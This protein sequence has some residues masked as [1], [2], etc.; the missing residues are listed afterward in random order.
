LK[1]EL[2]DWK[3]C[4][5]TELDC[6]IDAYVDVIK[7]SFMSNPAYKKF[8]KNDD[9][10]TTYQCWV[11]DYNA[12]QSDNMRKKI[13]VYPYQSINQGDYIYFSLSDKPWL[14]TNIDNI[15][16]WQVEGTI[17]KCSNY[18]LKWKD[19]KLAIYE[20]YCVIGYNRAWSGYQSDPYISVLD[21]QLILQTQYNVNTSLI[22]YNMRIKIGSKYYMMTKVLEQIGNDE[23]NLML[24]TLE[25]IE[26]LDQDLVYVS[27]DLA[28]NSWYDDIYTI[29]VLNGDADI[30]ISEAHQI[31]YSVKNNDQAVISDVCFT[32]SNSTIAT[33]SS[34][35]L[36]TGVDNGSCI[37]T[38]SLDANPS[39]YTTL[40]VEVTETPSSEVVIVLESN[41]GLINNG[42]SEI[43]IFKNNIT[44]FTITEFINGVEDTDTFTVTILTGSSLIE[45]DITSIALQKFT[46]TSSDVG[47][48]SIRIE[49]SNDNYVDYT[50]K[51]QTLFGG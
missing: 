3:N 42:D 2:R 16:E 19:A 33:V 6:D 35:G 9:T 39:V 12:L 41:D 4:G 15:F 13:T 25:Q 11:R 49:D 47:S 43:V 48:G 36:V 30:S 37:I 27:S 28:Y 24:F 29:E 40:T 46:L 18:T 14:C 32:S 50:I 38:I 20:E 26:S 7:S 44:E 8:Y 5:K 1:G 45:L 17:Q 10:E 21:N 31:D 22:P 51:S 23:S 34:T